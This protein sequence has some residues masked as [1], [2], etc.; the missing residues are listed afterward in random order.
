MHKYGSFSLF[1][2]T[3][4]SFLVMLVKKKLNM[5]QKRRYKYCRIKP[6]W[7]KNSLP[8]ICT[9]YISRCCYL[10][11]IFS[12]C[13]KDILPFSMTICERKMK[14]TPSIYISIH[15]HTD[16]SF[17]LIHSHSSQIMRVLLCLKWDDT[18]LIMYSFTWRCPVSLKA[19]NSP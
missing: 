3:W 4:I 11:N 16:L 10:I 8:I 6:S 19:S 9:T 7:E 5:K 14:Y 2:V 15:T 1:P 18:I 12:I 17:C 13:E